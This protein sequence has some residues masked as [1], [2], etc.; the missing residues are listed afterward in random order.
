MGL[1]LQNK[2]D[3]AQAR[4]WSFVAEGLSNFKSHYRRPGF[5]VLTR[6]RISL[7]FVVHI[8]TGDKLKTKL[9]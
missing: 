1:G 6:R 5:Q 2:D 7:T 9:D 8:Q 4:L 3:E